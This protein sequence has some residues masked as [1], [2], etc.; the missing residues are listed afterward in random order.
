[1]SIP[2]F[3]I[4]RSVTIYIACAIV[5]LLGVI[6]FERLPIDLMPDIEFPRIT[7]M[8]RYE[9]VA[10]GEMETLITRRVEGNARWRSRSGGSDLFFHGRAE[11]C[12]GRLRLGDRPGRGVRRAAHSARP[13]SQVIAGGQRPPDHVQV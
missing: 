2:D 6:S 9:G 11:P 1:M 10:P 8:T 13:A 7:V 5:V 4:R 3:A 12:C